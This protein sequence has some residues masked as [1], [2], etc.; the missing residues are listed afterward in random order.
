M[1]EGC[2]CSVPETDRQLKADGVQS[3]SKVCQRV[4]MD[5][6]GFDDMQSSANECASHIAHLFCSPVNGRSGGLRFKGDDPRAKEGSCE[7]L[8]RLG[9]S[10]HQSD[11]MEANQNQS[12][13]GA[14]KSDT[15]VAK[16]RSSS[17]FRLATHQFREQEQHLDMEV[18]LSAPW[19]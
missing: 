15:W 5:S 16:G 13:A 8:N 9:C 19:R 18:R 2:G 12:L 3:G 4:A 11:S 14:M 17:C 7:C 10:Q 1:P 6:N